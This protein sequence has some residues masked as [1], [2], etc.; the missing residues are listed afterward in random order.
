MADHNSYLP[1]G[2]SSKKRKALESSND[3]NESEDDIDSMPPPKRTRLH[4]PSPENGESSSSA[5]QV[6]AAR[7]QKGKAREDVNADS[8][9]A[10]ATGSVKPP[11]KRARMSQAS[12][13]ELPFELHCQIYQCLRPVDLL[14][15]SRV[16]R[17]F[18]ALLAHPSSTFIWR[19]VRI[20]NGIP[21]FAS[22]LGI[23]ERRFA[24]L[25]FRHLLAG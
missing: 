17:S 10:S 23:T 18:H 16:C 13:T 20:A 25:A 24:D 9:E 22:G 2:T 14:N 4:S 6:P 12:L 15:L 11:V 3:D 7:S 8:S 1:Q 5:P 19:G 21:D